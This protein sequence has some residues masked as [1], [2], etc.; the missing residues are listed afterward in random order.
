MLPI[1]W[2]ILF[3]VQQKL[4]QYYEAIILPI[5]ICLKKKKKEPPNA[6]YTFNFLI[7]V[8][9]FPTACSREIIMVL[10]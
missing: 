1:I 3:V 2:L 9:L 7:S 6:L 8:T 5:K 10:I 4:T